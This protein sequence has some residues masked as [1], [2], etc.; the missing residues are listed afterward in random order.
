MTERAVSMADQ[1][2]ADRVAECIRRFGRWTP[3]T[4][5]VGRIVLSLCPLGWVASQPSVLRKSPL[6]TGRDGTG[7]FAHLRSE[8]GTGLVICKEPQLVVWVNLETWERASVGGYCWPRL[9]KPKI[10]LFSEDAALVGLLCEY[11]LGEPVLPMIY[12]RCFDLFPE[13]AG[14]VK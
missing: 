5:R 8:L 12:D 6:I 1:D 4:G 9:S 7:L 10:K 2:G 3:P 11:R 14:S 13:W